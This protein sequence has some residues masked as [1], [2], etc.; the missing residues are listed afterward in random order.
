MKKT[1]LIIS[2]LLIAFSANAQDKIIRF[3]IK[4]GLN[5]S[6]IS[7]KSDNALNINDNSIIPAFNIGILLDVPLGN[8]IFSFQPIVALSGKGSKM[9]LIK[10]NDNN[11]ADLKYKPYYIDLQTNILINIPV[12]ENIEI[13]LGV[14]PYAAIGIFG[15]AS[16]NGRLFGTDIDKNYDIHYT[17]NKSDIKASDLSGYANMKR[18]DFGGNVLL[19]VKLSKF[20]ASVNYE[21]GLVNLHPGTVDNKDSFGKNRFFNISIGI[22][23]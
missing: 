17:T 6:T 22:I 19:G 7:I 10:I 20:I 3:G 12:V 14:G 21:H 11:Y 15:K 23:F 8:S 4:G 5:L 18:F 2:V 9:E 16:I 13:F 1:F